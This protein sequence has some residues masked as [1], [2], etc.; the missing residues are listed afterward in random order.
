MPKSQGGQVDAW[1][2]FNQGST[3]CLGLDTVYCS[4]LEVHALIKV[5]CGLI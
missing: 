2:D 1:Y 3:E 5:V 4:G